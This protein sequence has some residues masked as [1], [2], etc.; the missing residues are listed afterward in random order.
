[1]DASTETRIESRTETWIKWTIVALLCVVLVLGALNFNRIP[2]YRA[3]V[4]ETSPEVSMRY[5]QLSGQMDE[6]ALRKHFEGLAL[7]CYNEPDQP[8]RV[9]ER[10]CWAGIDKAD[11]GAALTLA[12]FLNKGRLTSVVVHVPWWVHGTW[13]GRLVAQYGK[14]NRAGFVS[15]LGGPVLRWTLPNGTL[16]YNRDQSWNPLEWSAVFWTARAGDAKA[17]TP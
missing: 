9:A 4:T 17:G 12:A 5:A 7:Q 14:A 11:G 6:T 15:V 16:E 1:M 8:G 13:R 3:W 2:T 10:I